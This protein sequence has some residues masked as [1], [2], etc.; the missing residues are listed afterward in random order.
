MIQVEKVKTEYAKSPNLTA[1]GNQTAGAAPTV[2]GGTLI[3]SGYV[4]AN[5]TFDAEIENALKLG[6]SVAGVVDE[7]VLCFTPITSGLDAYISI[8]F[9]QF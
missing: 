6:A 7:M 3:S 1:F 8:D 4:A 2:T 9:L 5:S